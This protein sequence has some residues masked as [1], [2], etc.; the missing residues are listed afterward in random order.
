MVYDKK[1]TGFKLD[2]GLLVR[3]LVADAARPVRK[4]CLIVERPT[5]AFCEDTGY[6]FP[7]GKQGN[8]ICGPSTDL[9][10]VTRKEGLFH[11]IIES[12]VKCRKSGIT[13]QSQVAES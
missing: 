5:Q 7:P 2:G 4:K 10:P 11:A 8:N 9:T 6:F 1:K 13:Q 12:N 3:H